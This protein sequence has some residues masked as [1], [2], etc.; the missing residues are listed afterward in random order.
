MR[1]SINSQRRGYQWLSHF[2]SVDLLHEEFGLEVCG[3]HEV[4]DAREILRLLRRIFP[5]WPFHRMYFKDYGR[6]IGWKAIVHRDPER[7]TR[8]DWA[9]S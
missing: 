5:S 1:R 4:A 6:E 2:S 9:S 8:R 3:I 7:D